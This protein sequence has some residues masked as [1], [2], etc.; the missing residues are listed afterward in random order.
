MSS[1]QDMEKC[2]QCGGIYITDFDC[3]TFEEYKFC[4]RCGKAE[5][6]VIQSD[7][8]NQICL[9][10]DGKPK[11]RYI[12][13]PGYGCIALFSKKG[14]GRMCALIEPLNDAIKSD[15]LKD[16]SQPEIDETKCYLTAW[17]EENNEIV[18]VFGNLPQSYDEYMSETEGDEAENA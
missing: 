18:A 14:M 17:D 15:F 7:E 5:Q 13:K 11:W 8:S 4:D 3:R 16:I 1:V 2:P 10:E 12:D 9:D 6:W